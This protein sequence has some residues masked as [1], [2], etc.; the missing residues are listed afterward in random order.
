MPMTGHKLGLWPQQAPENINVNLIDWIRNDKIAVVK[1]D[2]AVEYKI[3]VLMSD[4]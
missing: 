2:E 3:P 1:F 4:E